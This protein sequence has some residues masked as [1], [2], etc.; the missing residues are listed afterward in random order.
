MER[1]RFRFYDGFLTETRISGNGNLSIS[2]GKHVRAL[3]FRNCGFAETH[4][5]NGIS[6]IRHVS[7]TRKFE[8]NTI[9]RWVSAAS[10]LNDDS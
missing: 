9:I 2:C 3:R 7:A 8:G 1:F 6:K 4:Y 5:L 10:K